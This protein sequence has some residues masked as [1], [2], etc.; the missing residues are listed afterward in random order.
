MVAGASLLRAKARTEGFA[1]SA[2]ESAAMT[3]ELLQMLGGPSGSG[4]LGPHLALLSASIAAAGG[5][6]VQVAG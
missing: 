4:P 1:I 2:A 3:T 6:A 5:R